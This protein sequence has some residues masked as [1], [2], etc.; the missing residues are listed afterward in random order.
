MY[1]LTIV[2]NVEERRTEAEIS[3]KDGVV[4]AVVFENSD[5]WHKEIFQERINQNNPDFEIIVDSAKEKL[6]HYV[7]RKG[8]D[9]PA[10]MTIASFSLWLMTKDDGTTMG[11]NTGDGTNSR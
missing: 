6:S 10:H 7:N 9:A 5:G 8:E 3:G 11:M 2:G 4:I 1:S